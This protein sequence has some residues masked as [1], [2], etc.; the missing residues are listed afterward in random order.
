MRTLL[1]RGM[2]V[3]VVAGL[4]SLMFAYAFGEPGVE[5]GIAFEDQAARATGAAPG[6]ELVS[7]GVQTTI[8]LTTAIVVYGVALGGI[9]ALV[10][11]VAYGRLTQLSP[12]ATAAVL[13][14]MAYLVVF[15]VP[16]IKYPANPPGANEPSTISQ[17]TGLYVAL[18]IISVIAAVTAAVLARRLAPRYGNWN[19]TLLAVGAY[20]VVVGVVEFALPAVNET[21]AGFPAGVLYEFRMAALGTQV[22]LW[23]TLGLLF[24]WLTERSLRHGRLGGRTPHADP[25]G[26]TASVVVAPTSS[27]VRA[28]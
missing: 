21:P 14:L 18:V 5:G 2:I 19:A 8:G 25:R 22:V 28:D 13:A 15:V 27:Q 4:L 9:F 16:F 20:L 6:V 10:Y 7:R 11:A 3:G 12:R 23:A 17:R 1:I 26:E 24:G